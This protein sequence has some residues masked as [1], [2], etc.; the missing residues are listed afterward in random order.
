MPLTMA[1]KGSAFSVKKITGKDDTKRFLENLGF[2]E[3]VSVS[4]VSEIGG[5]LIINVKGT[6]VA[7]D[8]TLAGRIIV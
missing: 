4:V 8:R 3:G 6:R 7:L 1:G 2:I 5:N